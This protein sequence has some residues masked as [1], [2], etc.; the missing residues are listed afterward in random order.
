MYSPRNT[1]AFGRRGSRS[2]YQ[3]QAASGYDARQASGLVTKV[4]G[5]LSFSFLFATI[6]AFVGSAILSPFGGAIKGSSTL[7]INMEQPAPTSAPTKTP[8]DLFLRAAPA[9]NSRPVIK[10]STTVTGM[11]TKIS[12]NGKTVPAVN[13]VAKS[14]PK[15]NA[16][17]TTPTTYATIKQHPPP[18][19][20]EAMPSR[21]LL[22]VSVPAIRSGF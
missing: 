18:S 5:L 3:F 10:P 22:I 1:S 6:G 13:N 20:P 12:I 15:L 14:S 7:R 8:N 16:T 19:K 21:D 2:Q 17:T 9:P 11:P 4:M